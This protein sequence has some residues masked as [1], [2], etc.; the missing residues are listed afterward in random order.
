MLKAGDGVA[1]TYITVTADWNDGSGTAISGQAVFTPSQSVYASGVPLVSATNPVTV[2]INSGVLGTV[3]LLSTENTGLTYLSQT[4]FFYW[5]VAITLNGVAQPGFSFSL[6]LTPSSQGLYSLAN[7]G[8]GGFVNPMT[9][10]GDLID[11]GSSGTPQ[12]LGIGTTSQFLQVVSGAPAWATPADFAPSGLTGATAASR[13][14][15][16]T[17][18]GSPSSGTFDLGDFVID[19]SGKVWICTTAGT[20][21]TWT[22]AGTTIPLTTLGD[23]LY[24]NATPALARLAGNTSATKNFLTQTGTGSVSAAPAWGTIAAGDIPSLTT[25]FSFGSSGAAPSSGTFTTGQVLVD[26]NGVTRVCT[27]GGSPGTWLRAGAYPWQ[28]FAADYGVKSDGKILTDA[29]IASGTLTT[30]TSASAPF[31]SAD[32]GK[33]IIVSQAGGSAVLYLATTITYVSSTTV[34][35]ASAASAGG[36]TSVGAI[37]GTDDTAAWQD[38]INAA[39]SYAKT[40]PD[41]YAEVLGAPGISCIAGAPVV[42]GSTLGN[43]QIT[44]PLVAQSGYKITLALRGL[45]GAGAPGWMFGSSQIP[46]AG[47]VLACMRTDGTYDG[48]YGPA[49]VIGGPVYGYGGGGGVYSSVQVVVD[50]MAVLVSP[51]PTYG[52]LMLYGMAQMR[53]GSFQY[54]AMTSASGGAWPE[55]ST[56]VPATNR[57]ASG[58]IA[59]V[60]GNNDLCEIED[61]WTSNA[62]ICLVGADHLTVKSMR[63]ID[64]WVGWVPNDPAGANTLNH[65]ATFGNWSAEGTSPIYVFSGA[66]WSGYDLGPRAASVFI[67][68]LTYESAGTPIIQGTSGTAASN[69]QGIIWFEDLS[70]I[71]TL[72][73]YWAASKSVTDPPVLKILALAQT[74]GPVASPQAAPATTVAWPNW[75]YEDAEITLSVSGGSLSALDIDSVAQTVPASTTF[76][77]FTLPS[78]HSYTPTYTGTLTHT[79]TLL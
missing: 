9:T 62:A 69:L 45:Q 57:F 32:T 70:Q 54:V 14:A 34:T 48:T 26:Q 16:A 39:V 58:I 25:T 40:V 75:Y 20:P 51:E 73:T 8:A 71:N 22:Q 13:Y 67:A 3:K 27:S 36:V 79:V 59:P 37:Y 50:N 1:L 28:F 76:Y 77:R 31:T 12:R 44:L 2:A 78:G 49:S 5:T 55:V 43:A 21:G 11:G 42:G 18:S 46:V 35:L 74:H 64:S 72:P 24:E 6:P 19:Q 17:T 41:L 15:G 10:A 7:T 65:G 56:S 63:T 38:A 61:Y 47:C 52:G 33:H 23:T 60:A 4:G 53:I 66:S 30:L 68:T 29:T